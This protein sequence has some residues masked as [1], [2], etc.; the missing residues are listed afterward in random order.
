M[1]EQQMLLKMKQ[2]FDDGIK[3]IL[4]LCMSCEDKISVKLL[5]NQT[6]AE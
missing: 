3:I 2:L 5:Q 4:Q 6:H 1:T